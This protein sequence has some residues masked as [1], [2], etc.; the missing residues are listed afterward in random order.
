[1]RRAALLV[2][3]PLAVAVPA[4]CGG[5][6]TKT[7]TVTVP[8]EAPG[9]KEFDARA[10]YKRAAPGVVTII[11]DFPVGS[12]AQGSGFVVSRSGE[13]VTNAHVVND[14]EGRDLRP[15]KKV[16]VQFADDNQVP[17][18]VVGSDPDADI[19]LLRVKPKGLSLEP[20]ALGTSRGL[21]VGQDVAAIGSPFGERQSLSVGVITGLGRD[22]ESLTRFD[23]SNSIQTDAA[24]NRGNSGGPLVDSRARVIGVNAQIST[25]SG[26]ND[27]VGFAI[28]VDV[29]KRSIA[30]LRDGGR[31]PYAY[32]G[33]T[34][35]EVYPQLAKRFK[36]GTSRGAWL[37]EVN[38]NGP[39]DD[40]GL[41]AGDVDRRFQ[42]ESYR[43]GGD[44]ITRVG[45]VKV[46]DDG[47]LSTALAARRP[48]EK[49]DV[50]IF[51][52]GKKRTVS[53]RLGRRPLTDP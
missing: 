33:V 6:D 11:A 21:V 50:I 39:A 51:R 13:V 24:I 44:V 29:V 7:Q 10:V 22:I 52:K 32:L 40:A 42:A 15:A 48:G 23:V 31:V 14:G 17:A 43:V 36:L 20:L 49:V 27:G 46:R 3:A 38:A 4:G 34:T 26:G 19:A 35:A 8:A 2:L 1:V 37:Q 45:G 9:G 12:S 30:G 53:V 16:Y 18:R 47:D 41:R 25:T 28:P 5:G